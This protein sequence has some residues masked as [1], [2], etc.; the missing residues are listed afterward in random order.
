MNVNGKQN[1]NIVKISVIAFIVVVLFFEIISEKE[2]LYSGNDAFRNINS[3][4]MN[5]ITPKISD[6]LF[7]YF[8]FILFSV[9]CGTPLL[10][11]NLHITSTNIDI[12]NKLSKS[13]ATLHY[14]HKNFSS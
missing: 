12:K 10:Q 8:I 3:E 2:N 6:Y 1:I 4:R 13:E 9:V 7:Q 5:L 11:R 14:A